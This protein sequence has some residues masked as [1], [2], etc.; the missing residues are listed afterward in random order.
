MSFGLPQ[1]VQLRIIAESVKSRRCGK[2]KD[3]KLCVRQRGLWQ[4][5]TKKIASENET[6]KLGDCVGKWQCSVNWMRTHSR[7]RSFPPPA[8]GSVNFR[9]STHC[10]HN[11]SISNISLDYVKELKYHHVFISYGGLSLTKKSLFELL[12]EKSTADRWLLSFSCIVL[13][14]VLHISTG[15]VYSMRSSQQQQKS[16]RC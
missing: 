2:P 14:V 8:N 5:V 10:K 3:T 1:T 11:F 16:Y 4:L 6:I 7:L 12:T 13:C 15:H 9:H